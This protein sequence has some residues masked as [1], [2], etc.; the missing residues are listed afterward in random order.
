MILGKG[1]MKGT[2]APKQQY[3]REMVKRAEQLGD[4]FWAD[5]RSRRKLCS[6]TIR[7]PAMKFR[8]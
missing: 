2:V 5:S 8:P 1:K 6:N 3:L 7:L 4:Y